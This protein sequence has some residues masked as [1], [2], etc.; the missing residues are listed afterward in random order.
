M[1]VGMGVERRRAVSHLCARGSAAALGRMRQPRMHDAWIYTH[2]CPARL[3]RFACP[4]VTRPRY[5]WS[6]ESST[7]GG[8]SFFLVAGFHS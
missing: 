2:E 6:V 7:S 1:G 5:S 4:R 3:P 8:T